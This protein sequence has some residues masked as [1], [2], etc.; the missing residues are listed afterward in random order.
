MLSDPFAMLFQGVGQPLQQHWLALRPLNRGEVLVRIEACTLCGSDRHSF[1]GRRPCPTPSILGHEMLGTV[2]ALSQ[3]IDGVQ[4]GDRVTWSIAVHCGS[5]FFCKAGW[6]QKCERLFKY[7]HEKYNADIGPTGGLST[8]VILKPGTALFPVPESLPSEIITP[9]SCAT[10][11]VFAA[12]RSCTHL[13]E[14]VLI[15]GAGMLG[16]TACSILQDKKVF[17]QDPDRIKRELAFKL[18]AM[19]STAPSRGVDLVLE[20]SGAKSAIEESLNQ[21]RIGGTIVLVGSV[22]PGPPVSF[23]PEKI[24][25]RCIHIHG[26]HNYAPEDLASAIAYLTSAKDQ[27]FLKGLVQRKFALKDADQAFHVAETERLARV[28][29]V[30]DP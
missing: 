7:G 19:D 11:T 15:L 23:D 2:E 13:V 5:C 27:E 26:M 3:S 21:V 20:M 16:L 17:V 25:K 8:H 30:P 10:A 14:T 1:F 12:I 18:G 28:M 29:V 9:A 4:V 6:P 24:V 22:F